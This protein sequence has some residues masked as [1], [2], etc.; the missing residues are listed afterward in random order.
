MATTFTASSL[1]QGFSNPQVTP[2]HGLN[3]I[4]FSTYD[5]LSARKST[6]PQYNESNFALESGCLV[7]S[8]NIPDGNHSPITVSSAKNVR[9]C[10]TFLVDGNAASSSTTIAQY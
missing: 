1:D 8:E 3:E 7:I 9:I 6:W 2:K 10:Y 4:V 5:D